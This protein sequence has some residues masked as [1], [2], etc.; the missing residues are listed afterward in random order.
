[1]SLTIVRNPSIPA[2][3]DSSPGESAISVSAAATMAPWQELCKTPPCVATPFCCRPA[4]CGRREGRMNGISS[5]AADDDRDSGIKPEAGSGTPAWRVPHVPGSLLLTHPPDVTPGQQVPNG[6]PN[7]MPVGDEESGNRGR[8][9]GACHRHC[10]PVADRAR[11][12]DGATGSVFR[13][14]KPCR[15]KRDFAGDAAGSDI[16][17]VQ[18][19]DQRSGR[20]RSVYR[21]PPG[22]PVD[23]TPEIPQSART[24]SSHANGSVIR[25][26]ESGR[27]TDETVCCPTSLAPGKAGAGE[28]PAPVRHHRQIGT[29][30]IMSAIPPVARIAAGCT[31]HPA[32]RS[33]S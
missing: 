32:I 18:G 30:S 14:L 26:P 17:I 7:G 21:L 2:D 29:R 22:S 19:V 5:M 20:N 27:T 6:F 25:N 4:D 9:A 12:S 28:L 13:S 16:S 24:A 10:V 11:S 31:V 15:R 23:R 33:A 3:A 8:D 1:M